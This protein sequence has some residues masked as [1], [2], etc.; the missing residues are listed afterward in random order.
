MHQSRQNDKIL[1]PILLQVLELPAEI[2]DIVEVQY[3]PPG[4]LS[5]GL[6]CQ[7]TVLFTPKASLDAPELSAC[8]YTAASQLL[9]SA[10][11]A[12]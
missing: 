10:R 1:S 8:S 7:L 12:T 9:L 4:R 11:A 2:C 5:A 3:K 6:T